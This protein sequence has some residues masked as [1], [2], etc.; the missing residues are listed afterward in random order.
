MRF[1]MVYTWIARPVYKDLA[2]PYSRF[3]IWD[4]YTLRTIMDKGSYGT[5]QASWA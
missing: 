2:V 3:Q 1:N 5:I 4:L